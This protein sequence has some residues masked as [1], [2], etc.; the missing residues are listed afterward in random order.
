M[1]EAGI[2]ARY[3]V[4]KKKI[5]IEVPGHTGTC[6]N[7]DNATMTAIVSL[8][9]QHG[10]PTGHVPEYVNAIADRAPYNPV[11]DW[12]RSRSWDGVDRLPDIYATVIA[13]AEYT[14]VLKCILINKWLR[15]AVAAA[16]IPGFK[17]RG[18]LT[19]QGPQGIGKTSWVKALV[20]DPALRDS[21]VKLDHHMDGSDKDSVLSAICHWIVEIGELDSSFR[22]DIARLKGFLTRDSD[23]VRRPYD[24]RESEYPRRTVFAAT[25]ND[26]SFL[27]DPT[28]HSRWWTV[29]V[30]HL[31]YSHSI[32]T[33]QLFA[34]VAA[35]VDAGEP[36][37][38][39]EQEDE[40]LADWN[41]RHVATSVIADAMAAWMDADGI[42]LE[43]RVAVT[44]TELLHRLGFERPTNAQAKECGALL[45]DQFGPPK[46]IRGREKW[47]VPLREPSA[48]DLYDE[49]DKPVV[50]QP[51][52]NAPGDVF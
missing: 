5:E 44:P 50:K 49:T 21:V 38:L 51:V 52:T 28:G 26:P 4:I 42:P 43:K 13:Q 33:Q 19:F 18:V 29:A 27:V 31:D 40:L 9:A 37:W 35:E 17:G 1:T 22:R 24:R 7:L 25:V 45:R 39:T 16:L 11:A 10:M 12:I 47:R 2:Q 36:W 30:E 34:Q 20:N 41:A 6:D 46:R 8:C 48:A 3:N 15:S 23:R 14:A 32:D